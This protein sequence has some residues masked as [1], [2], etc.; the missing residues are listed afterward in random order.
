VDRGDERIVCW[1]DGSPT[2]EFLYVDDC[3][4]AVV[5]ATARY[6]GAEPVNIGTG[7]EIAI[8]DLT[9]V[10]AEVTGFGGRIAW[11]TTKPNGQPRRCLDTTRARIRFGL[12]ATTDF[13]TGLRRT[14]DWYHSV[15]KA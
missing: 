15:R 11:D 9:A 5:L 8:R 4:E 7:T 13:R 10:V 12:R 2:R 14:V 6:D 1:G 3:A